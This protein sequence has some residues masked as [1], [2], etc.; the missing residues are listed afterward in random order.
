M[1]TVNVREYYDPQSNGAESCHG[2]TFVKGARPIF[3]YTESIVEHSE[4]FKAWRVLDVIAAYIPTLGKWNKAHNDNNFLV[5]CFDLEGAGCRFTVK[6][7][8]D[9]EPIVSQDIEYTDLP[10]SLKLYLIDGVLM[11][12]SDY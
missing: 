10:H 1:D 5:A 9:S 8:S 11:F 2:Y 7:D 3:A 12:P 6:E 4:R